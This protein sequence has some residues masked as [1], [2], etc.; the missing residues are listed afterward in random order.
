MSLVPVLALC[1]R[2]S[3]REKGG[4][5]KEE[6]KREGQREG[7]VRRKEGGREQEGER[8]QKRR[9]RGHKMRVGAAPRIL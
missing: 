5:G 8:S 4:E 6:R 9:E 2:L 7:K 3:E 1:L